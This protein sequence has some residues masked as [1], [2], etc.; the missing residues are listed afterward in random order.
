MEKPTEQTK[1]KEDTGRVAEI[2]Q[3]FIKQGDR[4]KAK[5]LVSA[6]ETLDKRQRNQPM[7]EQVEAIAKEVEKEAETR[8]DAKKDAQL[9][10]E[11]ANNLKEQ[12]RRK[13]QLQGFVDDVQNE[14]QVLTRTQDQARHV[15][16]P[17]ISCSP[18]NCFSPSVLLVLIILC[19][20]FGWFLWGGTY[21]YSHRYNE[22]ANVQPKHVAPMI[23]ITFAL[24]PMIF[25]KAKSPE[26]QQFEGGGSRAWMYDEHNVFLRSLDRT[27]IIVFTILLVSSGLVTMFFL[28]EF[29]FFMDPPVPKNQTETQTENSRDKDS[30]TGWMLVFSSC[31]LTGAVLFRWMHVHAVYNYQRKLRGQDEEDGHIELT[32]LH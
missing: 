27:L 11:V 12:E 13:E 21:M 31:I 20:I 24:V 3:K 10:R 29:D 28:C 19:L 22:A 17:N 5:T 9:I 32:P 8:S 7:S 16:L 25:L 6:M 26:E 23:L 2:A 15:T 18:T 30:G 1:K 14:V 4:E